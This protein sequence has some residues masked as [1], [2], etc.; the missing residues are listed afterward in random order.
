M[1]DDNGCCQY[2]LQAGL[3]LQGCYQYNAAGFYEI[4]ILKPL[5]HGHPQMVEAGEGQ[6]AALRS[7]LPGLILELLHLSRE[8]HRLLT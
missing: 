6:G 7:H 5:S 4:F 1:K 8:I 2:L 3:P